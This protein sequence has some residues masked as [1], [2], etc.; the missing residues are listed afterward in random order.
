MAEGEAHRQAIQRAARVL[1]E[2]GHEI[3]R[4]GAE[5]C[6]DPEFVA[7]HLTALQAIDLIAQ[8]QHAIAQVLLAE[9][10]ISGIEQIGVEGLQQRLR[11]TG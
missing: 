10:P 2:L 1:A 7:R 3:E 11:Q 9:C 6:A 5:L 4:L 8:Q